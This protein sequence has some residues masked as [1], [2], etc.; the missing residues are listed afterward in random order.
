MYSKLLCVTYMV[1]KL[2]LYTYM[3]I[4]VCFRKPADAYNLYVNVTTHIGSIWSTFRNS[5]LEFTLIKK[6][7]WKSANYYS[8]KEIKSEAFENYYCWNETH[9][10]QLKRVL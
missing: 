3:R 9:A 5:P 10:R 7:F 1:L 6:E 8:F 4:H 2:S